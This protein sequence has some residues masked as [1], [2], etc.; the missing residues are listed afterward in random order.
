MTIYIFIYYESSQEQICHRGFQSCK[1]I[2]RPVPLNFTVKTQVLEFIN[3]C[4]FLRDH[5]DLTPLSF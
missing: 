1:A 5:A 4:Y 3:I 2:N